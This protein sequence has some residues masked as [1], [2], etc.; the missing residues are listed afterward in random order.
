MGY[1]GKAFVEVLECSVEGRDSTTDGVRLHGAS[2][3][4]GGALLGE[5]IKT[6]RRLDESAHGSWGKRMRTAICQP[7]NI[8]HTGEHV[9]GVYPSK[10]EALK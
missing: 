10:R 2:C 9:T 8:Y 5:I 7:P 4:Y 6:R 3:R 1:A